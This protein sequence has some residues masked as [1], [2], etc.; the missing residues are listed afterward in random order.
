MPRTLARETKRVH[1]HSFRNVVI[2]LTMWGAVLSV[3][4]T[5]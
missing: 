3:I 4:A 1:E 2:W 5:V